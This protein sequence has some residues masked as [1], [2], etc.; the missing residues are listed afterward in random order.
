M[1]R[2]KVVRLVAGAYMGDSFLT[3]KDITLWSE[4]AAHEA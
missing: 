4:T 3:Q 2:N 1:Y